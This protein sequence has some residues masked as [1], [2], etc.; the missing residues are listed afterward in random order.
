VPQ[1]VGPVNAV[2]DHQPEKQR[3]PWRPVIMSGDVAITRAVVVGILGTICAST[4]VFWVVASG[5]GAA[6]AVVAALLAG[7]AA[8]AVGYIATP[9]LLGDERTRSSEGLTAAHG[10]V[11]WVCV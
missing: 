2:P 7:A 1:S 5:G 8:G 4:A 11:L 10:F 6:S 3:T 9:S